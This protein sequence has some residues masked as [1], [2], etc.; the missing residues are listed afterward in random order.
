VS[1][2]DDF[3]LEATMFGTN[4]DEFKTQQAELHRRAEH[5]RLV[6][7]LERPNPLFSKLQSEL[8]R[9]LIRSGETLISRTQAAH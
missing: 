1:N 3:D 8:G 9:M 5:Y 6:K 2:I 7:S 4:L